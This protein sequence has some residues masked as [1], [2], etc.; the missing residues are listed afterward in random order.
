MRKNHDT[1]VNKLL[2]KDDKI[3]DISPKMRNMSIIWS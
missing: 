2:R 1:F 3:T